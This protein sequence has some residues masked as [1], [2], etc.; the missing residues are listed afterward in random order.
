MAR[1]HPHLPHQ[2]PMSGGD[3]RERDLLWLLRDGLPDSFDVFHGLT[4][5]S[6]HGAFQQFGELDLTIVSPNVLLLVLEVKTG[7]MYTQ[8]GQLLK[9]FVRDGAKD[10]V[11]R[12]EGNTVR[13]VAV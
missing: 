5:S 2:G 13:C 11:T 12:F 4:W 6:M 10:M 8:D 7:A 1:L 9:N 3:Y